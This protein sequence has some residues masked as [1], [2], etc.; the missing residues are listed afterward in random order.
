MNKI[1]ESD[2]N[3]KLKINEETINGIMLLNNMKNKETCKNE[4]NNLDDEEN[5]KYSSII[6]EL[7]KQDIIEKDNNNNYYIPSIKVLKESNEY[8]NSIDSILQQLESFKKSKFN[9]SEDN[10]KEMIEDK[11]NT[12][13]NNIISHLTRLNIIKLNEKTEKYEILNMNQLISAFSELGKTNIT[14]KGGNFRFSLFDIML[15]KE[16]ILNNGSVTKIAMNKFTLKIQIYNPFLKYLNMNNICKD[17]IDIFTKNN[18]LESNNLMNIKVTS[19]YKNIIHILES[20]NFIIIENNQHYLKIGDKKGDLINETKIKD[21]I[22]EIIKSCHLLENITESPKKPVNYKNFHEFVYIRNQIT[23]VIN[24]L[25]HNDTT[26]NYIQIDIDEVYDLLLN[27]FQ[28]KKVIYM[29]DN[30]FKIN[31]EM[32]S[33]NKNEILDE[34]MEFL[35]DKKVL[36]KNN[37]DKYSTIKQTINSIPIQLEEIGNKIINILKNFNY[38]DFSKEDK[39]LV[40][41]MNNSYLT[42]EKE[43]IFKSILDILMKNKIIESSK[44]KYIINTKDGFSQEIPLDTIYDNLI[45]SLTK[46][47]IIMNKEG[48]MN[49]LLINISYI[50][51]EEMTKN[52]IINELK[53]ILIKNNVIKEM[54]DQLM[55]NEYTLESHIIS[56]NEIESIFKILDKN[57]IISLDSTNPNSIEI[58]NIFNNRIEL[59]NIIQIILNKLIKDNLLD[60]Y[61]ILYDNEVITNDKLSLSKNSIIEKLQNMGIIEIDKNK[62]YNIHLRSNSNNNN[63]T[64]NNNNGNGDKININHN[65]NTDD[66]MLSSDSIL[67]NTSSNNADNEDEMNEKDIEKLQKS[68]I[69]N[70]DDLTTKMVTLLEN[71]SIISKDEENYIG[72]MKGIFLNKN[73]TLELLIEFLCANNVLMEELSGEGYNIYLCGKSKYSKPVK[74]DS[75]NKVILKAL[76]N[77]NGAVKNDKNE[78]N[79]N[80]NELN[81]RIEVDVYSM[82]NE[83][84][85]F[86][87]DMKIIELDSNNK[88][89]IILNNEIIVKKSLIHSTFQQF[90]KETGNVAFKNVDSNKMIDSILNVMKNMKF[91]DSIN[92]K[93]FN[94]NL[95]SIYSLDFNVIIIIREYLNFIEQYVGNKEKNRILNLSIDIVFNKN[96]SNNCNIELFKGKKYKIACPSP[97][98]VYNVNNM[99]EQFL[100]HIMGKH[101]IN[102]DSDGNVQ[103]ALEKKEININKIYEFIL[104]N[105]TKQDIISIHNNSYYVKVNNEKNLNI[106]TIKMN[107]YY[108]LSNEIRKSNLALSSSVNSSKN[109]I[110]DLYNSLHKLN[111][112]H[113]IEILENTELVSL[114]DSGKYSISNLISLFTKKDVTDKTKSGKLIILYIFYIL[115]IS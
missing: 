114:K 9:V 28:Q 108:L 23:G 5:Y 64:N 70:M 79:L 73:K 12:M 14:S 48:D 110:N 80:I 105:L 6:K 31:Y 15:S 68:G 103:I 95:S 97:T 92:E 39:L 62:I 84:M 53:N 83:I 29:E 91:I 34:I 87:K 57:K 58:I 100:K 38:L 67:C 72:N 52:N 115:I 32:N 60:N 94:L 89:T 78:I 13:F 99:N 47:N 93:D 65:K 113:M 102:M 42:I 45:N 81:S 101:I 41:M 22:I 75:L 24:N 3:N 21:G 19:I 40:N 20:M 8:K 35:V 111:E 7:E 43:T 71:N 109:S 36:F 46:K 44:N 106:E 55:T 56:S 59:S 27:L 50:E 30:E 11:F 82:I 10:D 112:D 88:A 25:I 54:D 1:I 76:M 85:N 37:H 18:P 33:I 69:I 16:S 66:S 74:K 49:S 77:A 61:K 107:M 26:N 86:F 2:E 4:P 51:R 17:I 98:K 90:V 96:V 104:E 63:N